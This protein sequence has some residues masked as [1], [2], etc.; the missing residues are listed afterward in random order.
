MNI[1]DGENAY[2]VPF[3][4][5]GFDAK[6]ILNIPRFEYKHDNT[7]IIKQWRNLLGNSKPKHN[8]KPETEVMV[9]V[10]LEY[11]DLQ[12]DE[13]LPIGARR[14]MKYARALELVGKGFVRLLE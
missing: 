2:I 14:K 10:I 8:Y 12:L 6:K 13:K 9:E 1:V 7:S 4:V 11:R 3:E 5:D